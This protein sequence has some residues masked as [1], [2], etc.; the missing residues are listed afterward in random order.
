MPLIT[1]KN[2]PDELYKA[3]KRQANENQRSI[4]GEIIYLI[5]QGVKTG[6]N[7]ETDHL[8]AAQEL[9]SSQKGKGITFKGIQAAID[10]HGAIHFDGYISFDKRLT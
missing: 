9:R 3:L 10:D 2:I 6:N 5:E 8:A 1:V 4:T 7:E